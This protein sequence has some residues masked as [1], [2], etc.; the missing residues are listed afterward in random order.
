MAVAGGPVRPTGHRRLRGALS[1]VIQD[2]GR[3]M[4]TFQAARG[5]WLSN[6]VR[7]CPAPLSPAGARA[8]HVRA[9]GVGEV[10]PEG[11]RP[12]TDRAARTFWGTTSG[13]RGRSGQHG[14]N[15]GPCG[16]PLALDERPS[17]R[18][19]SRSPVVLT[20]NGGREGV[21]ESS[22][23]PGWTSTLSVVLPSARSRRSSAQ[24]ARGVFRAS[25]RGR[26]WIRGV[27]DGPAVR[28]SVRQRGSRCPR[29]GRHV[30]GRPVQVPA[31]RSP[32]APTSRRRSLSPPT[33]TQPPG[34]SRAAADGPLVLLSA[35]E[36]RHGFC[37]RRLGSWD[38]R[39]WAGLPGILS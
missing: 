5:R 28:A 10:A 29:A 1:G 23:P 30:H 25:T 27:V 9:V 4:S 36:R 39:S 26:L 18:W 3:T 11:A 7:S 35:R 2:S 38:P 24:S 37:W 32:S 34:I 22:A 33:A 15:S 16:S 20:R 12:R 17:G 8:R 19:R 21:R 14:P 13:R 6:V 31:P